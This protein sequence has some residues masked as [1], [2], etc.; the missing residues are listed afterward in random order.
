MDEI[1]AVKTKGKPIINKSPLLSS[2][3]QTI[4]SSFN[5]GASSNKG[6]ISS[7]YVT[8]TTLNTKAS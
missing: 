7:P 4:G 8:K 5:R 1:T 6:S 3:S 2:N